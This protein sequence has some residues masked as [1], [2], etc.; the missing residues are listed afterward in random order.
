MK[1]IA[2]AVAISLVA[3]FAV[4][5]WVGGDEPTAAGPT[6]LGDLPTDASTEDRLA[7]RSQR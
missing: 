7:R 4:G 5:A 3:G 6:A 1:R 2:L